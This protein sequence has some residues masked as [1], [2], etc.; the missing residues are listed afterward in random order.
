VCVVYVALAAPL[1]AQSI[2]SALAL[3]QPAGSVARTAGST[4]VTRMKSGTA[5][6]V[7]DLGH[8]LTARHVADNCLR[9]AVAKEGHVVAASVVALS[10]ELDIALLKVPKTLGLSAIFPHSVTAA[11]NDMMFAAAYDT[12]PSMTDHGDTLGNAT[13]VSSGSEAGYLAIESDV[14]FGSSGAPVLDGRGLVQGVISG[15][16]GEV[17]LSIANSATIGETSM[18]RLKVASD[19]VLAVT[20]A[21]AKAFLAANGI[22][23]V[24]DDRPQIDPSSSRANRAASISARVTCLQ[25]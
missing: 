9:V 23:I 16:I 18:S 1:R 4:I 3:R 13:V 10:S 25:N 22:A 7:D 2:V 6:F 5:F 19:R 14:T 20:A 8:M 11:G 24:E 17:T 21:R 15:R 12:L